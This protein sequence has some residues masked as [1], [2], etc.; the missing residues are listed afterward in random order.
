[1]IRIRVS[2]LELRRSAREARVGV[3]GV[4]RSVGSAIHVVA[5]EPAALFEGVGFLAGFFVLGGGVEVGKDQGGGFGQLELGV[6]FTRCEFEVVFDLGA[7]AVGVESFGD[8]VRDVGWG[9]RPGMAG[10]FVRD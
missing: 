8:V 6:G 5:D 4:I 3:L 9:G 2:R 7:E 1:M 10:W